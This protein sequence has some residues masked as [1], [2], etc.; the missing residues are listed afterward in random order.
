MLAGLAI[1]LSGAATTAS[2]QPAADWPMAGQNLSNT[3]HQP[4][5]GMLGPG[6]VAGLKLKWAFTTGG[7]VSAT[8]AVVGDFL[9]V[10]DWAGNLFKVDARTGAAVWSRRLGDL[11]GL[12]KSVSRTTPAVGDG[13]LYVVTQDGAYLLALSAATGDLVWKTA[14]D[15]HPSAVITQSPVL[16]Q[17]RIYVGVSSKEEVKALAPGYKCCTFRGSFVA[18]DAASGGIVW[19]TYTTP[20]NG[21]QGGGYSGAPV[22]GS[23]PVVDAARGSVYFTT[24]QNY[25]VPPEVEACEKARLE[26]PSLPSCIVPADHIDAVVALD[27]QTGAVKWSRKIQGYDAWTFTCFLAKSRPVPNCP[28][29]RGPDYDFGQGPMLYTVPTSGGGRSVLAAGQKSG[30]F[31]G[32]DPHTGEVLWSTVV[33]PGGP[34]GGLMWGSAT[35]GNRVYAAE[36]NSSRKR[37]T[38]TPSGRKTRSGSWAALDPLTGAILWQTAVP[39]RASST[40]GAVTVANGV[41][42][43]SSMARSGDNMF[44]LD[45]ATGAILWRYASGASVAA[46]PAVVGDVVYWGSGYSSLGLGSS[47]DKLFAFELPH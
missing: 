34:I 42:F 22:W 30:L 46:G 27:L 11:V 37:Y 14:L 35:D 20:D 9:Y 19:R 43:A 8:P 21:G 3:R 32:V 38:L 4:G 12:A 41:V 26:D 44:A 29:P 16:F 18:V 5:A 23:T 24:G 40:I 6:T 39:G 13:A 31:W 47:N 10:P 7:D 1:L 17:Q 28:D 25:S 33:G 15:G 36:A 2:A 45:A